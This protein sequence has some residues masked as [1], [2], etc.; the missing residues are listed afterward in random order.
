MFLCPNMDFLSLCFIAVVILV[1]LKIEDFLQKKTYIKH[2][3]SLNLLAF[4]SKYKTIHM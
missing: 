1:S 2:P 3:Q 4:I